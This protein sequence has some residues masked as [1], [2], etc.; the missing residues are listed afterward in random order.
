MD[1]GMCSICGEESFG[2]GSD[3]I[4]EKDG[5]WAVLCW[6]SILAATGKPVAEVVRDHWR[7]FGRS[8]FQ[9]HDYEELEAAAAETMIDELRER[10]PVLPETAIAGATVALADD[11]SYTDPVDGSVSSNQG[12]RLLLDD[13]SRI[14]FRLSG[15]GTEGAT[16]RLYFERFL[17]EGGSDTDLV[18]RPLVSAARALLRLGE[19][20]GREHPTV[21]T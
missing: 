9:R 10:L 3:H 20:F 18:L 16:L 2:T 13:G 15:T 8:Y 11:F 5:L 1:A 7:R 19:R 6:L 21:V 4:R 17:P 12:I 14:I